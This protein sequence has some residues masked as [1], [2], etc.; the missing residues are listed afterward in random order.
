LPQNKVPNNSIYKYNNN[1]YNSYN[2]LKDIYFIEKDSNKIKSIN[3]EIVSSGDPDKIQI[4]F[5][6]TGIT[7]P[8]LLNELYL[9]IFFTNYN[10]L[11]TYLLCYPNNLLFV[12]H[13][14]NLPFFETAYE[15]PYLNTIR[16]KT[17]ITNLETPGYYICHQ[18]KFNKLFKPIMKSFP[19]A[20][21]IR[22]NG[23]YPVK[24]YKNIL[25]NTP[26]HAVYGKY[27]I[28]LEAIQNQTMKEGPLYFNFI[29]N[30]TQY[31]GMQVLLFETSFIKEDGTSDTI[32]DGSDVGT[33][34]VPYNID[35]TLD[36]YVNPQAV[37]SSIYEMLNST[38]NSLSSPFTPE[39]QYY[40]TIQHK[41][42]N[43]LLTNYFF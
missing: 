18:H 41:E 15:I 31:C 33:W 43:D 28:T 11:G 29:C 34:Y 35:G 38:F 12:T 32:Y 26:L 1:Y 7:P 25:V 30:G 13:G 37:S 5:I 23:S 42:N 16:D 40:F 4:L 19:M 17:E 36:I 21:I 8:V 6:E 20:Q 22:S 27:I 3:E 2:S 24:E 10:E 14:G 9:I 39:E